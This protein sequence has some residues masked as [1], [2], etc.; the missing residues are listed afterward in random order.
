[1]LTKEEADKFYHALGGMD[2][3]TSCSSGCIVKWESI[4]SLVKELIEKPKREI[5]VG[6]IYKDKKGSFYEVVKQVC[7]DKFITALINSGST[8]RITYDLNG[9]CI[10]INEFLNNDS[11][12]HLDLSKKYKLVEI[13][14]C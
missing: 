2:V 3:D 14:E 5:K 13:K 8:N 10:K 9:K 6:D 1:M 7:E 11:L 12:H 4:R